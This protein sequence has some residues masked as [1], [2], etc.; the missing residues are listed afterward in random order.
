LFDGEV[1]FGSVGSEDGLGSVVGGSLAAQRTT[2]WFSLV[3]ICESGMKT[4]VLT[5]FN[6]QTWQ[7]NQTGDFIEPNN[8]CI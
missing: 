7:S 2:L 3:A 5:C 6:Q 4:L 8:M 1:Q